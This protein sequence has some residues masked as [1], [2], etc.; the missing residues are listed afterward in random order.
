MSRPEDLPNFRKP[1]IVETVFSLQFEPV[2]GMTCSRIGVLWA[3]FRDQFP[4]TEEH[5]PLRPVL[6]TFNLAVPSQIEVSIEERPLVPRVWFVDETKA[7]LIQIQT[8]R[9][10]HNWRRVKDMEPYPRYETIRDKFHDEVAK[11]EEFL[12]NEELSPLAI[13]QCELTYVNH[14]ETAGIWDRHGQLEKVISLW[15]GAGATSILPAPEDAG[16]R[17]RFVIQDENNKPAGRLHV[18]VQPVWRNADGMPILSLILTARGAPLGP[19]TV[20]AFAFL[21]LARRWIV[22]GFADLTT[23]AMHAVWGR[24]DV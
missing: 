8:D 6:E 10:I 15:S 19:G 4:S 7:E 18:L 13:N 24:T 23:P 1:P 3:L 20:G 12:R 2:R 16:L 5:P 9:F 21:D 11:L 17:I 14:I 22:K